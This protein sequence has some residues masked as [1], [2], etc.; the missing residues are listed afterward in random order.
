MDGVGHDHAGENRL[1]RFRHQRLQRIAFERQ[2]HTG[3]V[4]DDR[5]MAG[6]GNSHFL[7]LDETSRR[8]NTSDGTVGIAAN[9]GNGAVLDD[10]D[11]AGGGTARIAPGDRI[12]ARRAGPLLQRAAHDRITGVGGN[13]ERRAIFLAFL[14]REPAI[15]D[16]V[17]TVGMNVALEAL[18]VM[19][20]M[21]EHQHAAL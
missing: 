1:D 5:C 19:H 21:G 8:F 11:T 17:Q 12:M 15:I 6:S 18:Y 2:A 9:G 13:A 20:V 16:A 14:G 7:G 10:I 4:H 3:C